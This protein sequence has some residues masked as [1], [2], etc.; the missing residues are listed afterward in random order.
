[1][2]RRSFVTISLVLLICLVAFVVRIFRVGESP[3]SLNWD[4]A[5]LGYNAYSLLK[6]GRDEYGKILP[7]SLRSFD[8]YKPALYS[9]LAIPAI[10]LG[11][12]SDVTT[13]LP[14]V[15]FGSLLPLVLFCLSLRLSN[16]RVLS[17]ISAGIVAF[18]PW[19][20]HF[21]RISFE[22]NVALTILFI[23][24]ALFAQSL[25]NFKYYY[26]SV[27]F[28]ILSMYTYHSERAIAIPLLLTLT[29]LFR[30]QLFSQIR[31]N[32]VSLGILFMILLA[33][34]GISFFTEPI[35]SRLSYTNIL[36]LWPFIPKEFT[37]LIYNPI[38]TL[39]WHTIGRGL[40]YFSPYTLFVMGSLEP[41]QYTPTLGLLHFIELPL[42]ICGLLMIKKYKVI[43]KFF[44][45]LLILAILPAAITW[46]WFSAVR[47]L[48]IYVV[49]AVVVAMGFIRIAKY[50]K[51]IFFSLWLVSVS[52]L[53]NT[54]ILYSPAITYGEYQPGFERAV[55]LLLSE[56][57]K[58]DHV[59]VDSP[60]I[61]PY[62]FLL[63][64]GQYEPALYHSQAPR[65]VKN[66]G[67]ESQPFGKFEFREIN[68]LVDRD[69]PHTLFMGPTPRLPD[70]EFE[71][72]PS[73]EIIADVY[74]TKGY[75]SLRIVATK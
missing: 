50:W 34:L 58:Y 1:M 41:G 67:T 22:S 3:P 28:F 19:S 21:S 69:L 7:I 31:R 45:P 54:E 23:A 64:Y 26:L 47:T 5:A 43:W 12:P 9:Y 66:S 63:F 16:N 36:K 72:N 15:V 32:W 61:A 40:A 4:E 75:V 14:S 20:I 6:T 70:Y 71:N 37:P 17:L 27:I 55:P 35:T 57:E 48:P 73:A 38:Y 44:L 42:W 2:E 25:T 30:N 59:I 49:F 39:I 11:N 74:D 56:S 65:R 8:D 33:P 46:N 29:F 68:W 52:Y 53:L 10:A 51:P 62:I 60:H 18:E 13:R 24:L